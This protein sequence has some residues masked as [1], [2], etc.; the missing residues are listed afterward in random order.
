VR[1]ARESKKGTFRMTRTLGKAGPTVSCIG[2]GALGMSDLYGPADRTE[3]IATI[4]AALNA[5]VNLIDTGDF[6]CSGHNEMLIREALA[7]INRED[8]V[9]SVKFGALRD[10]S[11]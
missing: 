8:Y 5:G 6:Y 2:L 11:Y 7:G 4:R 10:P 3:S 1:I 9:L